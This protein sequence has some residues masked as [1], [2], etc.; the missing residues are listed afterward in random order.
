VEIYDAYFEERGLIPAGRLYDLRYESLE[1]DLLGE[2]RKL[3]AALDL[4]DFAAAEPAVRGYLDTIAG[5][6]KNRFSEVQ[7]PWRS[8]VARCWRRGFDEW[9]YSA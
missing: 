3:Y 1:A 7:P 6:E 2:L 9:G 8:E 5:Y 4:P